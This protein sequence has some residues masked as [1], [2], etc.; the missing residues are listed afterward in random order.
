M[1]VPDGLTTLGLSAL[2]LLFAILKALTD[3]LC[4]GP[5]GSGSSSLQSSG[6]GLARVPGQR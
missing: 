4:I 3:R 6:T 1:N 5:R 2:I